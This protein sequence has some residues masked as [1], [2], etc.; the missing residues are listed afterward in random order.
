MFPDFSI[1][2]FLL[3]TIQTVMPMPATYVETAH[4][5]HGVMYM[6]DNSCAPKSVR[7]RVIVLCLLVSIAML[8]IMRSSR[9]HDTS[10]F[11]KIH[12][13][14][15]REYTYRTA[16]CLSGL[17][18]NFHDPRA[19]VQNRLFLNSL[20]RGV[21]GPIHFFVVT[22]HALDMN[23]VASLL[24]FP[25][26]DFRFRLHMRSLEEILRGRCGG[27]NCGKGLPGFYAQWDKIRVC[28]DMIL[29]RE[30]EMGVAYSHVVRMRLDNKGYGAIIPL[31]SVNVPAVYARFRCCDGLG[32]VH[33]DMFANDPPN[34]I[35]PPGAFFMDDQSAIMMREV[36]AIYFTLIDGPCMHPAA[37]PTIKEGIIK[38][39]KPESHLVD[40]PNVMSECYL[41]VALAARDIKFVGISIQWMPFT[42]Q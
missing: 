24:G 3:D 2:P 26:Q 20:L 34:F 13:N 38:Y 6:G 27:L 30:Q 7:S 29:E 21:D 12:T 25:V 41:T 14:E 8:I 39:C 28:W 17:V 31:T 35:C 1:G 10:S 16:I 18:R 9:S 15:A 4:T 37:N 40:E 42:V 33:Q 32:L 5:H 23:D 22:D 19:V 36:A 11:N